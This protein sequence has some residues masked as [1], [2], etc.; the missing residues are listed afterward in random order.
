MWDNLKALA[1]AISEELGDAIFRPNCG[2]CGK[3]SEKYVCPYCDRQLSACQAAEP[4]Q[5]DPNL[6]SSILLFAWGVYEQTLKQAIARC[7]YNNQPKIAFHLGIRMGEVWQSLPQTRNLKLPVIPVPMYPEKQKARGFNQ[8]EELAKGFCQVTDLPYQPQWLTRVKNTTPQMQ[9]KSKEEREANLQQAFQARVP[10]DRRTQS[11]IILDD[12]YTTGT[13]IRE[14]IK[15]LQTQGVWTAS[16]V[17]LA[18]PSFQPPSPKT[19]P[20]KN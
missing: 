14:A 1:K 10:S 6:P 15:A 4:I 12:I 7:K 9:T 5:A 13:T 20:V 17:V 19:K 8:A 11:V 2:L 3:V 18:R 16:V